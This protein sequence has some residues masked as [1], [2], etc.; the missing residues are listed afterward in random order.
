MK[1]GQALDALFESK[2]IKRSG[3]N[4]ANQCVYMATGLATTEFSLEPVQLKPVFVLRNA[5]GEHQPG[6]IPSMGDMMADDWEIL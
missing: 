4:G 1:F 6:W 2:R 3:W 5:Q